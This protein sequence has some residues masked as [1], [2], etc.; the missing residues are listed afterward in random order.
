MGALLKVRA[1]PVEGLRARAEH[2][3]GE[4]LSQGLTN[5]AKQPTGPAVL[6]GNPRYTDSRQGSCLH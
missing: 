5:I 1:W 6:G 4:L 2:T 3:G